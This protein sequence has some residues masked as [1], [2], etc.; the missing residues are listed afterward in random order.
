MT[1]QSSGMRG[2]KMARADGVLSSVI[3]IQNSAGMHI[4]ACQQWPGLLEAECSHVQ[5]F[6]M[7]A[8][9]AAQS[10]LSQRPI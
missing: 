10:I 8:M 4:M 7:N 2:G 6:V 5:A 1:K 9:V 3:D